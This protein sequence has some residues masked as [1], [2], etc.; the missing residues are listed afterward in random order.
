[1]NSEKKIYSEF[2]CFDE[3]QYLFDFM[4]KIDDEFYKDT[5]RRFASVINENEDYFLNKKCSED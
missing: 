1:V 5:L 4:E 2:N 3:E